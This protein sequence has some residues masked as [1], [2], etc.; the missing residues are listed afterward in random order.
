MGVPHLFNLGLNMIHIYDALNVIRIMLET[1]KTGRAPRNLI[2]NM[3]AAPP[4]EAHIWCWDGKDAV[5]TR[6]FFYPPYKTKRAKH[7]DDIWPLVNL[8]RDALRH[9]N[10]IQ[11]NCPGFEADD[12]IA[13]VVRAMP[14]V[15]KRIHST[16]RDLGQLLDANCTATFEPKIEP[17]WIRLYK[18]LVG[19]PSDTISGIP[20]FGGKAWFNLSD[21]QKAMLMQS[22]VCGHHSDLPTYGFWKPVV[23]NWLQENHKIVHDMWT[24]VGLFDVPNDI[25][26]KGLVSGSKDQSKALALLER[27]RH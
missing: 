3:L 12:V 2:T 11:Y 13:T 15:K 10:A 26:Q 27:F 23:L 5:Q 4:G 24:I 18:T 8:I 6:R 1:D 20:K 19:D 17:K 25:M 7:P 14:N 22:L 21:G 9:T 16:D